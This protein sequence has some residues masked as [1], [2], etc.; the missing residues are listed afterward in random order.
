M[1]GI[2][3][4]LCKPHDLVLVKEVWKHGTERPA[5]NSAVAF[6]VWLSGRAFS[7]AWLHTFVAYPL[8][9]V[10]ASFAHNF[11]VVPLE[12]A[13]VFVCLYLLSS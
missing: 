6:E 9:R 10:R 4:F 11:I 3:A 13:H 8:K 5:R 2:G 1:S 12:G 7:F